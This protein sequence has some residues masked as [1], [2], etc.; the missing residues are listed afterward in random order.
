M[1]ARGRL[2]HCVAAPGHGRCRGGR[3]AH[4]KGQQSCCWCRPRPT[5]TRAILKNPDEVD[6]YREAAVEHLTF[7]MA[8]TSAWARTLA[9]CRCACFWRSLCAPAAH[10]PG[11]GQPLEYLSNTSFRGP[12]QLWVEWGRPATPSVCKAYSRLSMRPSRRRSHRP[13]RQGFDHPHR[14]AQR[15]SSPRGDSAFRL[16][17]ADPQG[18]AAR[19][20][21]RRMDV[22]AG[23]FR[24]KYSL[25][26]A[27][28]DRQHLQVVI[29]REA[30][31]RGLAPLLRPV[32]ARRHRAT[33][34][35]QEPVPAG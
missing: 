27:A 4:P 29:Q 33:G 8:P 12:A 22:V 10:A 5:S 13:A 23:G 16:V 3:R 17:F 31:G 20:V 21:C 19:M 9:A 18:R 2:H 26:G 25:C 15:Q 24:R 11:G 30:E 34:R 32:A 7:D 6:V 1:P 35:P 14:G 28:D